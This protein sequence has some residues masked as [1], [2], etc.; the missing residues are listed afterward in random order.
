MRGENQENT[1]INQQLLAQIRAAIETAA[2]ESGG[3]AMH[4]LAADLEQIERQLPDLLRISRRTSAD[5]IEPYLNQIMEEICSKCPAQQ[6]S[7]FCPVRN[8]GGC[9]LFRNPRLV[10]NVIDRFFSAQP[11]EAQAL[12]SS[13]VDLRKESKM[14]RRILVAVDGPASFSYRNGNRRSSNAFGALR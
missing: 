13:R 8:E 6:C 9:I 5:N 14:F 2:D 7:G 4:T 3:D 10:I 11:K 1:A 12:A